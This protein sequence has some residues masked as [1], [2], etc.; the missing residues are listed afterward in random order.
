MRH[1]N[2]RPHGIVNN[3]VGIIKTKMIPLI[4]QLILIISLSFVVF[5]SVILVAY[6]Y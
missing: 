2:D 4:V 5:K 3:N 6:I 1:K